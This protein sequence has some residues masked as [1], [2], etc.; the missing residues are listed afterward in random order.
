LLYTGHPRTLGLLLRPH[1][2]TRQTVPSRVNV[3][4][5]LSDRCSIVA[6]WDQSWCELG[7]K[8]VLWCGQNPFQV[9]ALTPREAGC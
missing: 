8:R 7:S 2:R 4:R 1:D 9:R 5:Q 3:E 6:P